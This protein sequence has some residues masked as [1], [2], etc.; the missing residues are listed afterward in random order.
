MDFTL[1]PQ[2]IAF[3]IAS[4]IAIG[5]VL[6]LIGGGGSILA[7]PLLIYVVGVPSVHVA[8]GTSAAAVALNAMASLKVHAGRGNVKWPC[9]VVFGLAGIIGALAG[10]QIG[11]AIDGQKL[12]AL[13]GL[14][15]V[16]VGADMLRG[17]AGEGDPDVRLT[18]QSA[19]QLT[20][21]LI[22]IG[23]GVGVLSGFFGIGGGFLIVPGLMLAAGMP[24]GI[25]V[26]TS[27]VA[28]SA[29]GLTTAGSYAWSGFIDWRLVGL[30]VAGGIA[31]SFAGTAASI[32][33]G[34]KSRALS[35]I[36]AVIVIATGI[37]II[38]RGI[39]ALV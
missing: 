18:R 39:N 35:L 11:K 15:M 12:L 4:G 28:V 3:A 14:V 26:G 20:P 30:V 31:G 9:A 38:W 32:R 37:F 27:L 6:G 24:L 36:F 34:G 1:T 22:A 10:A 33:L 23:F 8:I 2:M 29:F 21:W 7:V 16:V 25:A 5:F 19:T 13:F 17:R